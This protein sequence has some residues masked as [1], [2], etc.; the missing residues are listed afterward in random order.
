MSPKLAKYALDKSVKRAMIHGVCRVGREILQYIVQ[1]VKIKKEDL[2][3]VGG[4]GTMKAS[5]L[6]GDPSCT[7]LVAASLYDT[8]P[9]YLLSNACDKIE[10]TK[11]DKLLWRKDNGKKVNT[12]FYRLNLIDEYNNGMCNVD[13]ADQLRLQ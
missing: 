8:K 13:Q 6:T 2:L 9:V 7:N 4:G 5:V 11:K 3:K 1:D 10:W 12:P